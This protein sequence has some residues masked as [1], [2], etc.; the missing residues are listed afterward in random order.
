MAKA[1]PRYLVVQYRQNA[2]NTFSNEVNSFDNDNRKGAEARYYTVCAAAAVSDK[3]IYTVKLE[4][5]EG[6]TVL[7]QTFYNEVEA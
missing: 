1:A 6:K 2:D 4:T 5:S 7:S 3:P